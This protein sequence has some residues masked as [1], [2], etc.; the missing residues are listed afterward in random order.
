MA[1]VPAGPWPPHAAA[2]PRAPAP[3]AAAAA[4]ASREEGIPGRPTPSSPLGRSPWAQAAFFSRGNWGRRMEKDP[5]LPAW[6]SHR[7]RPRPRRAAAG[8]RGCGLGPGECSAGVALWG[9]AAAAASQVGTSSHRAAECWLAGTQLLGV[10]VRW[11]LPSSLHQRW[12]VSARECG[13][14][15]MNEGGRTRRGGLGGVR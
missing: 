8:D 14:Q 1:G 7:L 10:K 6:P 3:G 12:P 11:P 13:K 2:A 15:Q 9:F 5:M 4:P